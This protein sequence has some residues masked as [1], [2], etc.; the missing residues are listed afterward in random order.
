MDRCIGHCNNLITYVEK[1]IIPHIVSTLLKTALTLSQ[2][3]QLRRPFFLAYFRLSQLQKHVRKVV[4]SFGK[5]SC[6]S[7]GAAPPGWLSG[8]RVGLMTW[9]CEFDPRWRQLFFPVYFRLSPLEKYVRKVVSG[10]GKKSC[11]NTCL[12][13]PGNT[14]APHMTLAVKVELTPIQQIKYWFEKARKHVC[15]TDCHCMTLPVEVALNSNT[16]NNPFPNKPWFLCVLNK[17]LAK[18]LWEK[19]KFL[20]MSNSPFPTVFFYPIGKLSAIFI[21]SKIV[22]CKLFQLRRV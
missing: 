9:C 16:T 11:V 21:K 10:F 3:S 5:K 12:I 22:V 20:V 7:T 17:S 1:G 8:E 18:N 4:G 13:K 14:Y 19:E 2:T 6:I 15:V